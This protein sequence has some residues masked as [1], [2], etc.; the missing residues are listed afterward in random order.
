MVSPLKI[1]FIAG[2]HGYS[3]IFIQNK[4]KKGLYVRVTPTRILDAGMPNQSVESYNIKTPYDFGLAVSHLYTYLP[5]NSHRMIRVVPLI[6]QVKKDAVYSIKIMPLPGK[7][8]SIEKRAKLVVTHMRVLVGYDI[9]LFIRP[10]NSQPKVELIRH[11]K[12]LTVIN[13]GN[14]NVLLYQGK[15]CQAD[16]QQ[17]VKLPSR[18]LYS[19]NKW[20]LDLIYKTPVSFEQAWIGHRKQLHSQ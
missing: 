6:D 5:V 14:T 17:C 19:G 2:K 3:D 18:R 11:G 12:R 16:G 13:E 15:Q 9:L 4:G 10:A 1:N 8:K 7:P 20:S